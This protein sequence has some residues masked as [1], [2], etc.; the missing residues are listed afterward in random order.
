M[1]SG[2][3]HHAIIRDLTSRW[4]RERAEL[5]KLISEQSNQLMYLIGKPWEMPEP[6]LPT[7]EEPEEELD[8]SPEAAY[9]DLSE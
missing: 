3:R 1:I 8:L 5:L 7:F 9:V 6:E 4:D 2:R